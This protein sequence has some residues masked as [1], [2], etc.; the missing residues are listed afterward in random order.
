MAK[1]ILIVRFPN[2]DWLSTDQKKWLIDTLKES[3]KDEYHIFCMQGGDD[4]DSTTVEFEVHGIPHANELQT[5]LTGKDITDIV[6][7]AKSR[8]VESKPDHEPAN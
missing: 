3:T 2:K 1:P 8:L 6:D 7:R 5:Y 4:H